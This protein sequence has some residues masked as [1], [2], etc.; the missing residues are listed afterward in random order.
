MAK[1]VTQV[2]ANIKASFDVNT[3]AGQIKVFNAQS[4]ASVSLKKV[5]ADFVIEAEGIMQYNEIVDSYGK[6]QECTITVIFGQDGTA[7]AGVSDTV[8]AAGSK[9]IDLVDR[10]KLETFNVRVIKQTSEK[11]NEFLNIALVG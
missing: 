10:L 11:G 4:G 3:Q 8:A 7:Y 6:P 5:P 1:E 2:D 9:L